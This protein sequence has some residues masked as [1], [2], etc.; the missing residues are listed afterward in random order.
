MHLNKLFFFF[1]EGLYFL[2][3]LYL[4][5]LNIKNKNNK[6]SQGRGNSLRNENKL[7][8]KCQSYSKSTE[9]NAFEQNTCICHNPSSNSH[10]VLLFKA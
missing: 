4:K 5:N 8:L 9:I 10:Q 7:N 2:R 1:F 3:K 6:I